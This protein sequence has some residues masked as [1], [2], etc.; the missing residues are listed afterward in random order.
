LRRD[1]ERIETEELR[2]FDGGVQLLL[3]IIEVSYGVLSA[4][5]SITRINLLVIIGCDSSKALQLLSHKWLQ[6]A[7]FMFALLRKRG[8]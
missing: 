8:C 6:N 1:E 3:C 4:L 7:T 2:R 5:L